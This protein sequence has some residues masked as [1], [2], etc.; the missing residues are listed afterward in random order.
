MKRKTRAGPLR[1][2]GYA[3]VSTDQQ[4][5]SGLGMEAQRDALTRAATDRGWQ[6]TIV[7]DAGASG[8]TL[9]RPG[10]EQALDLLARREADALAVAK[11]DRLT[12]SLRDYGEVA[13]L[14]EDQCWRLIV[15]DLGLGF[16]DASDPA[17][18][19]VLNMLASVSAYERAVISQRTS[20]ALRA[21]VARGETVGNPAFQA[22]RIPEELVERLR[23]L[24]AEDPVRWSYPKLAKL[25]NEEGV[26]TVRGGQ[27]WYPSTVRGVLTG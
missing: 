25:L 19:L 11:L 24:R 1:V 8:A 3:R 2:I 9:D 13:K 22:Q 12:R 27:R 5:D 16:D 10:L 17:T 6:L 15:L 14:A 23:Q 20:A 18:Q 7:E 21:K 26:P 4:R